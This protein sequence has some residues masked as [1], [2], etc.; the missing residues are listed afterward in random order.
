MLTGV[1]AL[2]IRV[3]LHRRASPLVEAAKNSTRDGV[4]ALSRKGRRQRRCRTGPR[5]CTG[6]AIATIVE[7]ADALLRG[8]RQRERRQRSGRDA[9][10]DRQL[11][12]SAAMVRRL[13]QAGA[14]PNGAPAWRDAADGRLAF[15]KPEVV[16]QLLAKGRQRQ[17]TRA[18]GQTA[19]MWAVAQNHP[20]SSRCCS[21]TAPTCTPDRTSG[22]R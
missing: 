15:G 22:A 5:R 4:R 12:G 13:L 11:N 9:A 19:L 6:R 10:L 1:R 16:E 14:N 17:R 3:C 8:R 2:L 18:R 21:R 20:T 7:S